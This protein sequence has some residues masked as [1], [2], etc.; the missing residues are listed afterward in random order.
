[1]AAIGAEDKKVVA[2]T[3]HPDAKFNGVDC[4]LLPEIRFACG[5]LVTALEVKRQ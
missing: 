2:I 5:E 1:M 3:F 4:A